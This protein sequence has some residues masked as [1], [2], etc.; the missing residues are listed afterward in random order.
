MQ[1]GSQGMT[2]QELIHQKQLRATCGA[3]LRGGLHQLHQVLD[4]RLLLVA[5]H[6]TRLLLFQCPVTDNVVFSR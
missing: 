2:Y 4:P 5:G 3:K 6:A 1:L